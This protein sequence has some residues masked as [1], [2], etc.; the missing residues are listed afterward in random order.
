VLGLDAL[1]AAT[2]FGTRPLLLEFVD[3]L[4]HRH[5]VS[6]PGRVIGDKQREDRKK[7]FRHG[8]PDTA[9]QSAARTAGDGVTADTSRVFLPNFQ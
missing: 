7:D 8:L 1:L 5:G 6:P 4:L 2:E 9:P 3:L